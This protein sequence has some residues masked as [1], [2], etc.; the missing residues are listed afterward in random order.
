MYVQLIA[1]ANF[2]AV[3][4]VFVL[5]WCLHLLQTIVEPVY[6][7]ISLCNTSSIVSV[8]L[9]YQLIPHC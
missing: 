9:W 7:N 6:N 5:L 8:I 2:T 3:G 4:T 1:V